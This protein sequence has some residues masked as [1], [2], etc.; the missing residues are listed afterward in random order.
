MKIRHG[1]VSNSS[2]T[3]FL[4]VVPSEVNDECLNK[5][6]PYFKADL[7][8]CRP[9]RLKVG[10]ED[11]VVYS[12]IESTE[13]VEPVY[14]YEGEIPEGEFGDIPLFGDAVDAFEEVLKN[15]GINF[16]SES[17]GC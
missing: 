13:D 15:A 12:R 14:G 8:A 2:T 5:I 7:E 6:H 4:I 11:V 10:N 3:S 9:K 16:V 17:E 1:F